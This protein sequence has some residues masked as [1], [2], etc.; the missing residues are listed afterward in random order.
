MKA[1]FG[2]VFF[3]AV[4]PGLT[5][6]LAHAKCSVTSFLEHSF[7]CLP[8][9]WL[10]IADTAENKMKTL[11]KAASEALGPGPHTAACETPEKYRRPEGQLTDQRSPGAT[12][13]APSTG[14]VTTAVPLFISRKCWAQ[15]LLIPHG[16]CFH[17]FHKTLQLTKTHL[18]RAL[19]FPELGF[20]VVI[21][22]FFLLVPL[23]HVPALYLLGPKHVAIVEYHECRVQTGLIHRDSETRR[24]GPGNAD[25]A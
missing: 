21:I 7:E 13:S 8:F 12:P 11:W 5:R 14:P 3:S 10:G 4:F 22:C 15:L 20:V 23:V 1:E 18:H 24:R 19:K 2:A 6:C 25:R 17:R 16:S 9:G